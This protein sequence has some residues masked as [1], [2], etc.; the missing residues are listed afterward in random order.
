MRCPCTL[1]SF[2]VGHYPRRANNKSAGNTCDK[3]PLNSGA[4]MHSGWQHAPTYDYLQRKKRAEAD[5]TTRFCGHSTKEGKYGWRTNEHMNEEDGVA[6]YEEG[7]VP[8]SP[9]QLQCTHR[10]FAPFCRVCLREQHQPCCH[11]HGCTRR[12]SLVLLL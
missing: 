4:H 9:R 12:F 1:T 8:S 11:P 2:Q 7:E 6:I 3:A 10:C 5:T